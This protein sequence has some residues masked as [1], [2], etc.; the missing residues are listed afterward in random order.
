MLQQVLRKFN[1]NLKLFNQTQRQIF[2]KAYLIAKKE[3]QT[4][5]KFGIFP[6]I[7]H[8]L[9][10]FN[11]L[12]ENLEVRDHDLLTAAI[13]H[14]SVEDG[15][16]SL[17]D[18]EKVFG[19]EVSIIV[20]AVTVIPSPDETEEEKLNSNL[21]HLQEIK[22]KNLSVKLLRLA[23]QLDNMSHWLEIPLLSPLRK[24]FPRWFKETEANIELA[25]TTNKTIYQLLQKKFQEI[26]QTVS[27]NL[28]IL[29]LICGMPGVRKSSTAVK[30]GGML[31]FAS[32]VGMDEMRDVVKLYDKRP[33]VQGKSHDRWQLFGS[34]NEKN[35]IKGFLGHCRALKKGA[36]AIIKK[37]MALGENTIVEGVHLVPFLYRHIPGYKKFHFLLVAKDFYHHQQM[38]DRK[39]GRRHQR[40]EPWDKQKVKHVERI[41]KY[42]V[43]DA[44]KNQVVVLESTTPEENCQRIMEYL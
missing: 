8:P 5:K 20:G 25:K 15:Q 22:N 31:N 33:I 19:K 27:E 10:I 43:Q 16:V 38:L 17:S 34:L 30:L 9:S 14:D 24:K 21:R 32:V 11:F 44:M 35:F 18:I 13:L 3:H 29:I 1:N 7:I 37:Q 12:V 4:Q 42:L 2:K 26:K 39:F 36:I 23:D 6:Y 28:P 41:Q 40:Q